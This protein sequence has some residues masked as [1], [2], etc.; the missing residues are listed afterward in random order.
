M[1]DDTAAIKAMTSEIVSAYALGNQFA[2]AELKGLIQS[3]YNALSDLN[4]E[5]PVAAPAEDL[6]STPAQ[7]RKSIRPDALVSFID[8]KPYKTLKRHLTTNGLTFADYKAKFGLPKDY[9][10]TAPEYSA[11]RSEMA[12]LLGLGRKA[13]AVKAPTPVKAPRKPRAP[14]AA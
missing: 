3:V 2:V 11:R 13:D 6:R 10:T 1:S 4:N 14:K 5:V 9:P 12:K 7:I 8:G